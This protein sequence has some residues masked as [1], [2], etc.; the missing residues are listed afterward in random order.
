MIEVMTSWILRKKLL[1][2]DVGLIQEEVILPYITKIVNLLYLVCVLTGFNRSEECLLRDMS[3]HQAIILPVYIYEMELPLF[4]FRIMSLSVLILSQHF[5]HYAPCLSHM[6]V[7]QGNIWGNRTIYL[8]CGGR[9]W[10]RKSCPCLVQ[11]SYC[12]IS[13]HRVEA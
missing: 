4:I 6:S 10:L 11:L 13:F 9:S 8:I 3:I 5:N 12:L 7:D 1:V 2:K